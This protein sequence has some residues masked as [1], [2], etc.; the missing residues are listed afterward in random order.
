MATK[1]MAIVSVICCVAAA[2]ISAASAQETIAPRGSVNRVDTAARGNAI[3]H[4]GG[5]Q[6]P[7]RGRMGEAAMY[8]RGKLTHDRAVMGEP[9]SGR[10]VSGDRYNR[11]WKGD[12]RDLGR[13]GGYNG[14]WRG[15]RDVDVGMAGSEYGEDRGYY[16]S[17]VYGYPSRQLYAYGPSYDTRYGAPRY[18][19]DAPEIGIGVGPFGLGVGPA[20]GW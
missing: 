20:W 19:D 3:A 13:E 11:D 17:P 12:R 2:T 15:D 9:R 14:G 8:E 10:V 4:Q 5:T 16:G 6:L 7:S 1:R 18:Y